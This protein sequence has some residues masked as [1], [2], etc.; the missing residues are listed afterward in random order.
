[1]EKGAARLSP[2]LVASVSTLAHVRNIVLQHGELVAAEAGDQVGLAHAALETIGDRPQ[3]RVADRMSQRVIDILEVVEI[4]IVDGERTGAA[5]GAREFQI[6]PFEKGR[7]VGEPGQRVGAR[8]RGDFFRGAL[9]FGDVAKEPDASEVFSLRVV[10][11]SGV[12]LDNASVGGCKLV[13]ALD[14]RMGVKVANARREFTFVLHVGCH[15]LPNGGVDSRMHDV[16]RDVPQLD[17]MLI[18][19]DDSIARVD[20]KDCVGR[21]LDRRGQQDVGEG[22]LAF[23][24]FALGDIGED[25]LDGD[26]PVLLVAHRGIRVLRAR[27]G[28]HPTSSSGIRSACTPF[29]PL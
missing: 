1:M 13:V 6:E 25:A 19:H 3:Q 5:L 27:H 21:I 18:E 24:A 9:F 12:P 23:G 2:I 26:Q 10:K 20:H 17:E 28:N 22:Q 11:R 7:P 16:R 15:R 8:Q 29:F 4:E 14:F